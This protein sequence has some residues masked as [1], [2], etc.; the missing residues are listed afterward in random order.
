MTLR[1]CYCCGKSVTDGEEK[2]R[3]RLLTSM[4]VC[5]W[6]EN[7]DKVVYTSY[8]YFLQ[9]ALQLLTDIIVAKH[10]EI[11][12]TSLQGG[13]VCRNCASLLEKHHGI[14]K[15]IE[16]R[17]TTALSI[18]PKISVPAQTPIS[19]QSTQHYHSQG[20]PLATCS[21]SPELTVR[22]VHLFQL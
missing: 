10:P 3:R 9:D 4:Q 20:S 2:K 6:K 7:T 17:L 19:E 14:L 5:I 16:E 21:E 13:Y 15:D 1:H 12:Q 8:C 22:K 11:D 18:L